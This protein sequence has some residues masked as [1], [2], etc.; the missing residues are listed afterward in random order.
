MQVTDSAGITTSSSTSTKDASA[1]TPIWVGV[2]AGGHIQR[3]PIGDAA[4]NNLV[5]RHA[6]SGGLKAPGNQDFSAHSLRAGFVTEAKARGLDDSDI[7]RHPRHKSLQMVL[8]Y[9]Q[10]TW[11]TKNAAGLILLS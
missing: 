9:N 2:R 1:V 8:H 10:G 5:K 4:V 3:K 11:W 7:M 6:R